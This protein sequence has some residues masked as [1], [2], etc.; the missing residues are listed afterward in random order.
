[1]SFIESVHYKRFCC[2]YKFLKAPQTR[3][4]G[5]RGREA[6][7][8]RWTDVRYDCVRMMRRGQRFKQC[9]ILWQSER[10]RKRGAV[11]G[12][13]SRT[14]S[15]L[16]CS[17]WVIRPSQLSCLSSSVGRVLSRTQSALPCSVWVIRPSQLS[18]L[19]SSVGRVLFRTQSA[20]PCSVWVIRPSQLSC[21]SN[22][23]SIS[24]SR[25][26]SHSIQ[27]GWEADWNGDLDIEWFW[28]Q[29]H[30]CPNSTHN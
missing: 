10:E 11:S 15:A 22:S 26:W 2:S 23:Q 20:L 6:I 24:I 17:V 5:G 14:Q 7:G 3:G 18:C 8:V 13:L 30:T 28:N 12:V 4:F 16:P 19:S 9:S 21:L 27:C 1:M 25:R 29:R